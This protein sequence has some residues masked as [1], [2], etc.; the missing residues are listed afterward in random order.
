MDADVGRKDR[1]LPVW[2]LSFGS[3]NFLSRVGQ[4]TMN[5]GEKMWE[6]WRWR[7]HETV[8]RR[9]GESRICEVQYDYWEA[10]RLHFR[11]A[12]MNFKSCQKRG[13]FFFFFFSFFQIPSTVG[14]EVRFSH[15]CNLYWVYVDKWEKQRCKRGHLM[16]G[17]NIQAMQKGQSKH[18]GWQNSWNNGGAYRLVGLMG[19]KESWVL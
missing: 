10:L 3:F 12:V 6:V 17:H 11:I 8:T 7:E 16:T 5:I 1:M 4:I 19:S 18:W 9:G 13:V 15:A 2:R 14:N